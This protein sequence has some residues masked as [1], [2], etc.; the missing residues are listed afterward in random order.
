MQ[1]QELF[2]TSN[3]KVASALCV[4]GFDLS[5]PAC[6]RMVRDDGKESVIFWFN[7]KNAEGLA[8]AKVFKQMTREGEALNVSDPENPV[9]FMRCVLASRDGLLALMHRCPR[10]VT[11]E[12]N[13]NQAAIREDSTPEQRNKIS[14]QL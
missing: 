2:H 5:T 10:H 12:R 4:L 6:S 8:A 11:I 7:P 13:G 9:N 14:D 1:K 3:L